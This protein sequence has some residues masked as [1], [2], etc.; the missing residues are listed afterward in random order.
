VRGHPGGLTGEPAAFCGAAE[1]H[2]VALDLDLPEGEMARLWATLSVDERGRAARLRPPHDRRFAAA[3]GQ[4]REVLSLY[5]GALPAALRFSYAPS[6]KPGL[7]GG[8]AF[9]LS[10][11]EGHALLALGRGRALGVDLE[12]V[13]RD[14]DWR[15]VSDRV[16]TAAERAAIEALP[17]LFR[18]AA[19][20]EA[21]TRKEALVK[22][23]G[24]R[25]V[26]L[27]G[28]GPR[29]VRD[30]AFTVFGVPA[31]PG[32]VAAL[33][34]SGRLPEVVPCSFSAGRI[35]RAPSRA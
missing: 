1:V 3:R 19:F 20:F 5:E 15:E 35:G 22:A 7:E 13:Q 21:W 18:T 8:H 26:D 34:V 14:F 2:L 16:F 28:P 31:P 11:C 30:G 4:L 25:L 24:G 12:R 17:A 32:F 10:R 27:D 29:P 23:Q 33:A 6:G 9:N